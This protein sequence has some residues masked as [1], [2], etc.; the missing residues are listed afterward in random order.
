MSSAYVNIH[1][2][3][4]TQDAHDVSQTPKATISDIQMERGF[5]VVPLP[6]KVQQLF[7]HPPKIPNY[8][9][10]VVSLVVVT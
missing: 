9:L 2:S 7:H 4:L 1:R 8:L 6:K 3:W 5:D 10:H